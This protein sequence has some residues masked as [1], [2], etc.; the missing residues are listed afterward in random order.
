MGRDPKGKKDLVI[1]QFS[2]IE[3]DTRPIIDGLFNF[4]KKGMN[5][6]FYFFCETSRQFV[7]QISKREFTIDHRSIRE[8]L[9]VSKKY[10]TGSDFLMGEK[11]NR[12][13]QRCIENNDP[14]ESVDTLINSGF[15]E[16]SIEIY[17]PM[18]AAM[19]IVS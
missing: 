18:M 14:F 1:Y 12:Y 3:S 19:K 10:W 6:P 16:N 11:E 13:I 8:A 4:Y 15:V 2:A 7:Q 9:S 17:K 5:A